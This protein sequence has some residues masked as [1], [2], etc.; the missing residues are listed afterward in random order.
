MNDISVII[1]TLNEERHIKRAIENA[2]KFAEKIFIVDSFS[3]DATCK[4]A[5]EMNAVVYQH[6]WENHSQQFQ[7]AIDNLPVKTEWVFR[8]DADEY[9]SDNLIE[10]IKTIIRKNDGNING[11]TASRQYIFLGRHI[12]H[13]IIPMRPLRL[14]RYGHAHIENK[15]MDEHIVLDDGEVGNLKGCFYD[16]SLMTLSEWT[17]KHN[18]YST[19]EA[20]D[21][22][23][24]KYA[25]GTVE[26]KA[27]NMAGRHTAHVRKMKHLYMRMP[28]F[29]RAFLFF[30]YRYFIRLG[31]LDGKEGFMWHFLQGFWYRTLADAKVYEIEKKF[32]FDRDEISKYI[33]NKLTIKKVN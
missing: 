12:K 4:I 23:A 33:R 21:L 11:Y 28:L 15:N 27:T 26:N 6:K 30:C 20:L 14:F 5:K 10:E 25:I 32:N 9:L 13:G 16:A 2:Q 1:L 31:F 22:L 17:A 18:G 19:R 7:W 8:L 29:F 24:S 3:T